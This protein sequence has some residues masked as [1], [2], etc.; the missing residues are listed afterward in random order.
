MSGVVAYSRCLP[1][2]AA[3]ERMYLALGADAH[4]WWEIC[5]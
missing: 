4:R 5:I 3:D 1:L 2:D